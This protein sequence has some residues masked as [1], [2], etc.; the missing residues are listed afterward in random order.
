M[1][2]TIVA[3]ATTT[4]RPAFIPKDATAM[5]PCVAGLG[6]VY[7][8]PAKLPFGPTYGAYDGKPIFE[9]FMI[10]QK[11]FAQGRNWQNISVPIRGYSV[12]HVDVWFAPHGHEGAPAPHYDII[13]FFVPHSA[14]MKLC[15][16]SGKLPD[17]VLQPNQTGH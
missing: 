6:D 7:W 17:F 8:N 3:L 9:E 4:A 5:A 13:L 1:L 10:S 16:P 12:D 14:H 2:A 15:N 11:E